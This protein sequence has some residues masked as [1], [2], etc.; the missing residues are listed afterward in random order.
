MKQPRIPLL[1]FH[2]SV[3]HMCRSDQAFVLLTLHVLLYGLSIL[4]SH[5]HFFLL[6]CSLLK[7]MCITYLAVFTCYGVVH[8]LG[9][10]YF[11]VTSVLIYMQ[12]CMHFLKSLFES[13]NIIGLGLFRMHI[14]MFFLLTI[15]RCLLLLFFFCHLY[16]DIIMLINLFEPVYM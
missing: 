10:Y 2:S 7:V 15:Y 3:F 16:P 14:I 11:E 1:T 5:F 13:K 9:N 12:K 8:F 4:S 6:A